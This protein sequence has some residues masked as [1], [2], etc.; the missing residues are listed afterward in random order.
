MGSWKQGVVVT[1]KYKR[2]AGFRSNSLS[3]YHKV[4]QEQ[5]CSILAVQPALRLY[6]VVVRFYS[7]SVLYRPCCTVQ[8]STI[9]S[10]FIV[11]NRLN[12]PVW[13]NL[14]ELVVNFLVF[15]FLCFKYW[16]H[17]QIFHFQVVYIATNSM[18]RVFFL[19]GQEKECRCSQSLFLSELC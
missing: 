15:I 5:K 13:E 2:S 19:C 7:F 11:I 10:N 18:V 14:L 9:K 8:Q 3:A 16:Q 1:A 6:N 17:N 4:S 12:F